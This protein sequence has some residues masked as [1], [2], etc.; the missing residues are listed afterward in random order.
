M[1]ADGLLKL[2]AMSLKSA[3]AEQIS[4]VKKA[5]L[6]CDMYQTGQVTRNRQNCE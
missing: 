3:N 5:V 6:L 4:A 1:R 2:S